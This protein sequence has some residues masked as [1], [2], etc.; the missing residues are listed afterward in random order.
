MCI[1][2]SPPR[3]FS[4]LWKVLRYVIDARV[5]AKARGRCTRRASVLFCAPSCAR[6]NE[7]VGLD[8]RHNRM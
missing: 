2:Y 5:H 3:I 4:L 6:V 7:F 1:I 8:Q